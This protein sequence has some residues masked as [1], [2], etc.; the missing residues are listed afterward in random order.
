MTYTDRDYNFI[1]HPL[2]APPNLETWTMVIGSIL[3][4]FALAYWA[5]MAQYDLMPLS[6]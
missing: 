6:G 3:I 5:H 2:Y 4:A 1:A